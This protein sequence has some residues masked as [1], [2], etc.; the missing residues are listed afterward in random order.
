MLGRTWPKAKPNTKHSPSSQ[1]SDSGT[2][3]CSSKRSLPVV[4]SLLELDLVWREADALGHDDLVVQQLD[5]LLGRLLDEGA[6]VLVRGHLEVQ[7]LPL[8]FHLV[9]CLGWGWGG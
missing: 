7:V 1:H 4:Y 8:C 6:G 5:G 9:Q 2:D 3:L